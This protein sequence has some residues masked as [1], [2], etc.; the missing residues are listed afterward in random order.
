MTA[1]RM[2]FS[3]EHSV[4][5]SASYARTRR[6]H[7]RKPRAPAEATG[8]DHRGRRRRRGGGGGGV[9]ENMKILKSGTPV[10]Q[11]KKFLFFF[12]LATLEKSLYV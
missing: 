12:F 6:A 9:A 2:I 1:N 10:Y 5:V 8:A 11:K 3:L 4:C 7:A